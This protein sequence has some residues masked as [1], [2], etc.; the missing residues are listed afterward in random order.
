MGAI[1]AAVAQNVTVLLVGRCI[2]GV[3]WWRRDRVV[4]SP[5]DRSSTAASS[6]PVAGPDCC[7]VGTGY[8]WEVHSLVSAQSNRS[9]YRS[10]LTIILSGGGFAQNV[11]WRWIFWINLPFIGVG[12]IV[13]ALFL[14]LRPI[15]EGWAAKLRRI[16]YVG[17]F[18]FIGSTTSFLIPL[19]WGGVSF[20]WS[21]WRTL[22]PLIIGAIGLVGFVIWEERYAEEP[23][24]PL[25]IVKNRSAAVNYLGG[26]LQG[27]VLCCLLYYLPLY[28]EGVLGYSPIVSGVALFP[29]TFTVAPAAGTVGFLVTKTGRY[30]WAIWGGWFMATLGSGL[31]VLLD[32]DTSIPAWIFLTLVGGIGLGMLFPSIMFGIQAA[33][34]EADVAAAVSL[35]TFVRMFGQAVGVAVGG[36]IFQNQV[37]KQILSHPLIAAHAQ[38]YAQ[39]ASSLVQIIKAMPQGQEKHDLQT[40]YAAALRVVWA[41]MCGL[42]F[43]GF[44]TSFATKGYS[45]DREHVVEQGFVSGGEKKTGSEKVADRA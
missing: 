41:L 21:S 1:I 20:A 19:S 11:S 24:I 10:W 28:Y 32:V 35:F 43:I 22:V 45:L 2:Q 7:Y 15:E 13:I 3:G 33:T 12:V 5:D 34:P 36:V 18:I 25:R 42:C 31:I 6:R 9:R 30:R 37:K 29:E 23:L 26:F 8:C 39:D 16:D 40:S 4:G 14:N 44:V 27:L 17:S 38:Q